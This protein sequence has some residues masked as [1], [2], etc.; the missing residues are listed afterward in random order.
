MTQNK[1]IIMQTVQAIQ[2]S[3]PSASFTFPFFLPDASSQR[4]RNIS[5]LQTP[6]NATPAMAMHTNKRARW[7]AKLTKTSVRLRAARILM[8]FI[9]K[10]E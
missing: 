8:L 5:S 1:V 2:K 7:V 6:K 3:K 9:N 4:K 10:A